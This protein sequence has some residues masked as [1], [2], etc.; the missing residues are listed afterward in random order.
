[1]QKIQ[2]TP[3][4][5]MAFTNVILAIAAIIAIYIAV[6]QNMIHKKTND[7]YCNINCVD[8]AQNITIRIKNNGTGVMTIKSFLVCEKDSN[9]QYYNFS[10]CISEDIALTYYSVDIIGRSIA[11]KDGLTL[12]EKKDEEKVIDTVVKGEYSKLRK[13][14]KKYV[15]KLEYIDMY[16]K[17]HVKEKDLSVIYGEQRRT[18]HE[19][20]PQSC[21]QAKKRRLKKE[22]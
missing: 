18:P 9:V 20:K 17:E 2:I 7:P 15:L 11:P 3:D 10:S 22:I 19:E 5:V 16:G 13:E 12:L 8:C 14:L 1:M 6:R 21:Q 4:L